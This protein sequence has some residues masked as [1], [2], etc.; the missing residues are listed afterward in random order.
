MVSRSPSI[1]PDSLT[2]RLEELRR[3]GRTALIP[4]ITAGYPSRQDTLPLMRALADAGADII[5]LGVPFSDPV[6]DGPTIQRSSQVALDQGV[7]LDWVLEQ[8]A[9]FRRTTDTP[10]IIFTYLNPLL[11]FGAERFVQAA[12][13]A[14]AQGVLV[15]DLPLDADPELERSLEE[16]PL[17]LVRLLAPTTEPGRQR[18]ILKRTQGFAYYVARLGVTGARASLRSE[19]AT[20]LEL[21]KAQ[22]NVPIAVGFGISNAEQARTVARL[23]DGVVVGSALIEVLD[24]DGIAGAG[25]WLAELRAGL[26]S[27]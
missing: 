11:N 18:D 15:V 4:Y 26:D 3:Q 22:A 16:S 6:A 27:A 7:T 13:D 24:R 23:A 14:G 17:E 19:L 5:E 1:S 9:V 21:L 12:V 2:H 25:A 10:V 20:E 8:L